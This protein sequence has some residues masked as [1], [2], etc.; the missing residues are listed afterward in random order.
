MKALAIFS[1]VH[2]NLEALQAALADME[3]IPRRFCL[4]DTVGYAAD[5]AL[6]VEEI[7]A[8]DCPVLMGNHDE[9]VATNMPLEGM[10]T[11]AQAG[12]EF[13]RRELTPAQRS[14]LAAL[15][16]SL[17][18]D[19]HQF[20][21]GSLFDPWEY[22]ID[23]EDAWLHFSEQ[24]APVCFCGHTHRPMLWHLDDAGHLTCLKGVGTIRLPREGKTLVNVGSVGQPR[25][26]NPDACYVIYDPRRHEVEFR[27]VPYDIGLARR[28]IA[29]ARLPKFTAQRLLEGR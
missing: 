9:A 7:R 16:L 11:P 5:P 21:H 3:G 27:R 6:C 25:D 13:S 26:Y 23:P 14:W 29:E 2:S 20:I 12:I 28:K 24:T 18:E 8:L 4:G 15:P 1:D 10:N 22:V 17:E 19:G